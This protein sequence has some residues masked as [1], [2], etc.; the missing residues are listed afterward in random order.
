MGQGIGTE[1]EATRL[2]PAAPV[3]CGHVYTTGTISRP[4]GFVFPL[5]FIAV[6]NSAVLVF[7]FSA[8]VFIAEH[9]VSGM[10]RFK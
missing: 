3:K 1:M 5:L 2:D 10:L 7:V 4:D 9:F 8:V 6:S